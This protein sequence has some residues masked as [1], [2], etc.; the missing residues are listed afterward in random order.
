MSES[1]KIKKCFLDGIISS[2]AN[3]GLMSEACHRAFYEIGLNSGSAQHEIKSYFQE[4]ALFFLEK[5][6]LPNFN[7]TQDFLN[8]MAYKHAGCTVY[9]NPKEAVAQ[10]IGE[11][12]HEARR[13]VRSP[14]RKIS[15]RS[16]DSKN[17]SRR[18]VR[19][20]GGRPKTNLLYRRRHEELLKLLKEAKTKSTK[21]AR[22]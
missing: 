16:K 13:E 17:S 3:N 5:Q 10:L 2:R 21:T 22:I 6:L 1:E 12:K 20:K 8:R 11:I 14:S 18:S 4:E 7:D 9:V 19:G 15:R